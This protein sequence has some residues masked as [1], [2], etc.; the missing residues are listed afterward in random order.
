[1]PASAVDAGVRGFEADHVVARTRRLPFHE[2]WEEAGVE[3]DDDS[4]SEL[5]VDH[6]GEAAAVLVGGELVQVHAFG[7]VR[8]GCL[9]FVPR[10]GVGC[11]GLVTR[12]GLAAGDHD[13][14]AFGEQRPA[15]VAVVHPHQRLVAEGF[16]GHLILDRDR[17]PAVHA[18]DCAT[19]YEVLAAVFE[20]A[21]VEGAVGHG[22]ET[23]RT[24][25][26]LDGLEAVGTALLVLDRAHVGGLLKAAHVGQHVGSR[27]V[28]C[29]CHRRHRSLQSSACCPCAH[30]TVSVFRNCRYQQRIRM[31]KSWT[32]EQRKHNEGSP[33]GAFHRSTR[34]ARIRRSRFTLP[35]HRPSAHAAGPC[36]GFR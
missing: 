2:V 11:G 1:M 3:V 21:D 23:Q 5:A 17:Q 32:E 4:E 24:V 18:G 34:Y 31:S 28:F 13:F 29:G 36:C 20:L 8:L 19:Q 7:A 9:D 27:I 25:L 12:G 16:V 6:G 10:R 35:R 33:K 15:E 30:H 26:H 22:H 14:G